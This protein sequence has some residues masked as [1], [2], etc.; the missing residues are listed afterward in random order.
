MQEILKDKDNVIE[1]LEKQIGEKA[2]EPKPSLKKQ[3]YRAIKGDLVDEVMAK[4][5]N[6]MHQPLPVKRLGDGNYLF[7]TK[8]IFA[9]IMQ[10]KLVI[11]VGGGYMSIEEFIQTYS[12]FEIQKVQQMIE[13]GLFHVDEYANA[14]LT[15]MDLSPSSNHY[16]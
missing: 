4:Y 8:K 13:K 14:D 3:W 7:G 1:E 11:R 16:S 12:D 5:L 15:N 10:G 9:R 6:E 2:S